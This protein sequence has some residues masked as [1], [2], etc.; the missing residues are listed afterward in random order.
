MSLNNIK[1]LKYKKHCETCGKEFSTNYQNKK[2]CDEV[3]TKLCPVCNKEFAIKDNSRP[4]LTCSHSCASVLSHTQK[5]R[6]TRTQRSLEKYGTEHPF[7]AEEV[8]SKIK[9]SLD[10]SEND[11]RF[12][13]ENFNKM[14]KSKFGVDNISQVEE[15]KEKKKETLLKNYDVDN[16]MRSEE[17]IEKRAE[18]LYERYG[19]RDRGHINARN[20]EELNNLESFLSE[21]DMTVTDLENYFGLTRLKIYG[22]LKTQGVEHLVKSDLDN[23]S[24]KEYRLR[25]HLKDK[26]P[27]IKVIINERRILEGKEID[28]YFP[29]LNFGVEISP[30]R[31]HN[32]KTSFMSKKSRITRNYHLNKFLKCAEKGVELITVFDWHDWNKVLEMIDTKLQNNNKRI[33]ARKTTYKEANYI[34]NELFNKINQW[35]ILNLNFNFKRKNDV[36]ILEYEDEIVGLA[37]WVNIDEEK[38]ELK[39]LAFKPGVSVIGGASKLVNNYLKGHK[40]L[41][42]IM[43]YSD[44]D[45]GQGTVYD[46]I[47]FELIEESTAQLNFY[48]PYY[49]W[50]IKNLSLVMI[51]ADRLLRNFPN[52]EPVGIGE[53]L[54][55]NREIVESYGFLPVYD[56]G[57]RKWRFDVK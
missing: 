9:E 22:V 44:C 13:S 23:I 57:Y 40:N 6:E 14:I 20:K 56:C 3:H 26:F 29:D 30:T 53:G 42:E 46:K 39:R 4:S 19:V 31:T 28:F 50:H 15:I 41:K 33:F 10:N 2:Y 25:E 51:G 24:T 5:A 34:D 18:L 52:Y 45:L 43:T 11:T 55:G 48:H 7:Q 1:S 27:N 38:S 47:G 36:G 37:V 49:E 17:I 8:K 16:P 21:N 35:H 54:P 32:T 12:G